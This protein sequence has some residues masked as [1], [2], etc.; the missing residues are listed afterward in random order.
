MNF[1]Y[2]N[3]IICMKIIQT[4]IKFIKLDLY[5]S[6]KFYEFWYK[7]WS[8]DHEKIYK[9]I[10]NFIKS[11]D[12]CNNITHTNNEKNLKDFKTLWLEIN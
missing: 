12:I 1:V 2:H 8:E 11:K 4:L 10:N 6:E 3:Q 5:W 9:I 7:N